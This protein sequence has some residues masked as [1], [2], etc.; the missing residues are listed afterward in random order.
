MNKNKKRKRRIQRQIS[1]R[2]G[3]DPEWKMYRW[4]RAIR[5]VSIIAN[6]LLRLAGSIRMMPNLSEIPWAYLPRSEIHFP[7]PKAAELVHDTKGEASV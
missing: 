7:I 3:L 1:K 5:D 6:S 2:G 4:D